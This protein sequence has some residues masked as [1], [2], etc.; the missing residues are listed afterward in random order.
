MASPKWFLTCNYTNVKS[1]KNWV[2]N[3]YESEHYYYYYYQYFIIILFLLQAILWIKDYFKQIF[4]ILLLKHSPVLSFPW[5]LNAKKVTMGTVCSSVMP[6]TSVILGVEDWSRVLNSGNY[7]FTNGFQ[8]GG[9]AEGWDRTWWWGEY[10]LGEKVWL[11][12]VNNVSF[13]FKC[14]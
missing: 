2:N 9:C 8:L 10:T 4:Q 7:I 5:S 12:D 13:T 14:H 6:L 1:H 11:S 3:V